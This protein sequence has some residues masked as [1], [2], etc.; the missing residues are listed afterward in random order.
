MRNYPMYRRLLFTVVFCCCR[1]FALQAE[2]AAPAGCYDKA[3]T[4]LELNS[5]SDEE[6][7][8]ADRELNR[9]Y[10]AIVEKYK[11]DPKF[12]AKLRD[13]QRAW[14]K[15]RDAEFEAKFPHAGEA[16]HYGSIFPMCASQYRAELTRERI[17]KLRV[18][19]DGAEEGDACS[20]S[21]Q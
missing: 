15:Y 9:L 2:E 16:N 3:Q 21:V 13:A 5:C 17:A 4:Q 1:P 19:L 12:I 8:S 7:A 20:G 11:D 18:W 10:K 14:L 6:Y